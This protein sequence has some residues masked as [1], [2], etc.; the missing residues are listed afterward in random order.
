LRWVLDIP[1]IVVALIYIGRKLQTLDILEQVLGTLEGDV[2]NMR[3]RFVV[4]EDRVKTLWKDEFAPSDSPRQL[5]AR[6]QN[7]LSG[8][9][10]KEVVDE[11]KDSLLAWVKEKN[12]SNPYDAEQCTLQ[13]VNELKND[14][15]LVEKLKRGA[16]SVGADID[17][18]LLVGG[19]YLRDLIFPELGFSLDDLDLPKAE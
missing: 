11:K 3:D 19:I 9:G 15:V 6:G 14:P 18:V 17:S 16:F 12:A 2:K 7:V 10:I 8:S 13:A 1:A 5:N 4:V